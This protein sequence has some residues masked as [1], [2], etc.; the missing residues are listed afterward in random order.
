MI[1]TTQNAPICQTGPWITDTCQPDGTLR[2][3]RTVSQLCPSIES[4]AIQE[5][6][7]YTSDW[8]NEP[9]AKCNPPTSLIAQTRT[10]TNTC[11]EFIL[12]TQ[13]VL[14]VSKPDE[15]FTTSNSSVSNAGIYAGSIFGGVLF[16]GAGIGF[17]MY[18]LRKKRTIRFVEARN[19]R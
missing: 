17:L 16:L 15:T 6:C 1:Y 13:N 12:A 3:T 4:S 10:K 19:R 8:T 9:N 2:K 5:S 18:K 14:R 11:D 7:C